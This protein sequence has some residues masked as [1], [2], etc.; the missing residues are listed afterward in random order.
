MKKIIFGLISVILLC[1][2]SSEKK[3]TQ[4]LTILTTTSILADLVQQIVGNHAKVTSMM[5][6]GVDPHLYQATPGD[7]KKI[8]QADIIFYHGLHLEGKL[9]EILGKVGRQK[10]VVNVGDAIDKQQ[11]RIVDE[12]AVDPHIW[13]D[14][15]LWQQVAGYVGQFMVA[16]DSINA[17]TYQNST[18]QYELKLQE[19]ERFIH[20]EIAKIP[21]DKRI[22]ITAH[23]AFGYFGSAYHV[24]VK[25]LQGISTLSNFGVYDVVQL[26]EFIVQRQVKSIFVESS[27]SSRSIE[28]VIQACQERGHA[29][30][31]GGQLYSDALGAPDGEAGTYI[32]M[33]RHNV[34]T[35][36]EGLR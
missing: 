7:L 17:V 23:D 32:G 11:L 10:P 34:K 20:Q 30:Q 26:S 4:Q 24:E 28:A 9:T 33:V 35:M 19:L 31:L 1:Q 3:T 6:P 12:Q 29:V 36:V 2:C 8:Q 5:G 18:K 14:V 16:Y 25:G 21:D 27:V 22:L 15:S 13:F